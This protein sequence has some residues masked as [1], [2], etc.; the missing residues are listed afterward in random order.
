VIDASSVGPSR[1]RRRIEELELD[2][3]YA[4]SVVGCPD[5]EVEAWLGADHAALQREL[6]VAL[7]DGEP[8]RGDW[9]RALQDAVQSAAVPLLGDVMQ[10]ALDLVPT[11]DLQAAG[12]A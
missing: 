12:A 3:N 11:L 2:R 9:K 7:P 6:G 5:P 4:R 10:L 8:P 1:Q